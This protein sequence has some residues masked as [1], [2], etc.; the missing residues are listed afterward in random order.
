MTGTALRAG[1]LLALALCSQFTTSA[2]LAG[3]ND[4]APRNT[5]RLQVEYEF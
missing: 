1:A 2:A 4:G 5:F 3:L